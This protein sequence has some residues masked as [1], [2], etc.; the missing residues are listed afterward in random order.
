LIQALGFTSTADD[1]YEFTGELRVLK[2]GNKVIETAIE[3]LMVA[4]MTPEERAKHE[5]MAA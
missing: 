4:R 5:L 1:R 3:P 2:K